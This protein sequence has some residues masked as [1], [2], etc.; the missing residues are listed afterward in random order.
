MFHWIITIF[1]LVVS[2]FGLFAFVKLMIAK[3]APTISLMSLE[4]MKM[5]NPELKGFYNKYIV[6]Q[7]FPAI[8]KVANNNYSIARE[9]LT[10]K[11]ID[12]ELK[13]QTDNV[14]EQINQMGA[15]LTAE[16]KANADTKE[17]FQTIVQQWRR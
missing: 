17:A 10:Y 1:T 11:K 16:L 7:I 12:D 3:E 13:K 4:E 9:S 15:A 14:V 8:I 2:L 5:L 6:D